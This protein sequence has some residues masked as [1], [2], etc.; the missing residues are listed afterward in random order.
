MASE[1]RLCK[2][3]EFDKPERRNYHENQKNPVG[4]AGR[5]DDAFSAACGGEETSSSSGEDATAEQK[6]I[7][8]NVLDEEQYFN[9][10]LSAEPTTLDSVVGN[11][12]YSS[13]VLTN[14]MEPLTRLGEKRRTERP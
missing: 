7:D 3:R 12:T 10:Y 13:S 5:R 2:I 6:T 8:G 9:G 14:V 1:M 11:D 4:S